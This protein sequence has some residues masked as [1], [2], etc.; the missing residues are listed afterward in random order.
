ML[1]D[2]FMRDTRVVNQGNLSRDLGSIYEG[3]HI[4]RTQ[5]EIILERVKG[6]FKSLKGNE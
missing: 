5:R 4:V 3:T 2:S 6:Y 1:E